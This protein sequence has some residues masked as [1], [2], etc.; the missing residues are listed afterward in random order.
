[1]SKQVSSPAGRSQLHRFDDPAPRESLGV[2]LSQPYGMARWHG[3]WRHFVAAT[4]GLN[5]LAGAWLV[6][7]PWILPY[8]ARDPWWNDVIF[9]LV[10]MILAGVRA[11][12]A[13]RA[14]GLS[15]VNLALGGWLLASAFWLDKTSTAS[16]NDIVLGLVVLVLALLSAIASE[17]AN[18]FDKLPPSR[19][20][21]KP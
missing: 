20:A 4:S 9:G 7:A 10:V 15:L 1:M 6:A 8:Q 2:A 16:A 14:T 12:G 17:D 19:R 18:A 21:I 13:F 11:R 5:V 3:G